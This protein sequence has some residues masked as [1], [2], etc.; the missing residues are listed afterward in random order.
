MKKMKYAVP[1][2]LCGLFGF[3]LALG[4][5]INLAMGTLDFKSG[6][7]YFALAVTAVLIFG[8]VWFSIKRA[9]YI[10]E[11]P[12]LFS[13]KE[14]QMSASRASRA[15]S[16]EDTT[17]REQKALAKQ[18]KETRKLLDYRFCVD[19]NNRLISVYGDKPDAFLGV[20]TVII[21]FG[22]VDDYNII[23]R[24]TSETKGK[25]V[26]RAIVGGMVGGLAGAAVG[27]A[28]GLETKSNDFISIDIRLKDG[29][30][31]NVR[32]LDATKAT[33]SAIMHSERAV[34]EIQRFLD[35][36]IAENKAQ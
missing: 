30:F 6:S 13:K 21:R 4:A 36:I 22:E 12:E 8:F 9:R 10:K 26:S 25:T 15:P 5:V 34:S 17:K 7:T 33:N 28:S 35:G 3:G 18:F 1:R 20:G 2:V 14:P 31:C 19:D 11:N 16:A 29:T 23:R 32:V 27:A 24:S